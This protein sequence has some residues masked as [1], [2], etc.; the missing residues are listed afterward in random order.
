[1]TII[2]KIVKKK[3]QKSPKRNGELE[4][5]EASKKI[6]LERRS[7]RIVLQEGRD[8]GR[9]ER[10][11]R[12]ERKE[13]LKLKRLAFQEKKKILIAELQVLQEKKKIL[14]RECYQQ[15][16]N[17]LIC[18]TALRKDIE[19]EF[20]ALKKLNALKMKD[21]YRQLKPPYSD[22]PIV[23]TPERRVQKRK[24]QKKKIWKKEEIE[25]LF[26]SC[27]AKVI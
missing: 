14:N 10:K 7:E 6:K 18:E 3:K 12:Q 24:V 16:S 5:I 25:E 13:K 11:A 26:R 19:A 1:M 27:T 15:T 8:Q 20:K 17:F 22:N 4:S 2:K 21:I 9:A 23:T